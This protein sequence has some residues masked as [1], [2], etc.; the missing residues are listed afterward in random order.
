MQTFIF[1][2][3]DWS[4]IS[5]PFAWGFTHMMSSG[6]AFTAASTAATKVDRFWLT[7]ML[8]TRDADRLNYESVY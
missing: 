4:L 2:S 7:C 5:I 8:P 3:G 1:P 6:F